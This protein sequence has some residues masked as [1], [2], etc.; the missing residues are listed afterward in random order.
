MIGICIM[1]K[2]FNDLN[3]LLQSFTEV[4]KKF[5]GYEIFKLIIVIILYYYSSNQCL[6]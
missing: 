1:W 3:I 5:T 6:L 2:D 4:I